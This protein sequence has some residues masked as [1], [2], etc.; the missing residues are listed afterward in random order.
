MQT[1][2]R[3]VKVSSVRSTAAGAPGRCAPDPPTSAPCR[4]A[5]L[6]A[7][8]FCF[9]ARTQPTP[10][11]RHAGQRPFPRQA[12]QSC[13]EGS[14]R[15]CFRARLCR[16]FLFIVLRAVRHG[17]RELAVMNARSSSEAGRVMRPSGGGSQLPSVLLPPWP[18]PRLP[19]SMTGPGANDSA[20]GLCPPPSGYLQH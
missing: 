4:A 6:P 12:L 15:L 2:P 3:S 18:A 8:V 19:A 1:C 16:C 20:M 5:A 7:A 17:W 11:H 14:R 9:R 13:D 10:D